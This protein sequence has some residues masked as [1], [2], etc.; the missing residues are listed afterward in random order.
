MGRRWKTCKVS[1][2]GK[3]P[4][5]RVTQVKG[6]EQHSELEKNGNKEVVKISSYQYQL[7]QPET[8]KLVNILQAILSGKSGRKVSYFQVKLRI[9]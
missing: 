4:N 7:Q 2:P 8:G 9:R 5:G 6:R 3:R 1:V